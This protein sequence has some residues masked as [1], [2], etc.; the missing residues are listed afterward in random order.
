MQK[1]TIDTVELLKHIGET[2]GFEELE[3]N[4][5]VEDF[6]EVVCGFKKSE[7]IFDRCNFI[8]ENETK[9]IGRGLQNSIVFKNCNF[10][11]KV[12]WRH[13]TVSGL[14]HGKGIFTFENCIFR[15]CIEFSEITLGVNLSIDPPISFIE[16]DLMQVTVEESK[17]HDRNFYLNFSKC[18][19]QSIVISNIDKLL[20]SLEF[21]EIENLEI[22]DIGEKVEIFSDE[23]TTI[24]ETTIKWI[25]ELVICE[26]LD[27]Q[28]LSILACQEVKGYFSINNECTLSDSTFKTE[29]IS[30]SN[31][32]EEAL[33]YVDDC[34]F[35][36]TV[37]L[38]ERNY[39]FIA[40]HG[41][42]F[43]KNLSIADAS[44][45][46]LDFRGCK[47]E[48][49]VEI[50]GLKNVKLAD[51]SRSTINGLFLFSRWGDERL[52]FEK[53]VNINFSHIYLAPSGYLI[54]RDIN[55]RGKKNGNFKFNSANIL[56]TVVFTDV[57]VNSLDLEYSS[58]VGNFN[59]E[60][61]EID[62]YA[63]SQTLVKLKNEA[64]KKN[65]TIK[66]LEYKG[67][68][69]K[70]YRR[71][72]KEKGTFKN[73]KERFLITLNTCS[74]NNGQSW[75]RGL[76]FTL[77][78]AVFFC[79]LLNCGVESSD[80]LYFYYGWDGW[81]SYKIILER[82]LAVINIFDFDNKSETLNLTLFGNYLFFISKIF[83]GYGIYQTIAAFRKHGK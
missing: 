11:S 35:N 1:M 43:N 50:R 58:I 30:W 28:K 63:N 17:G 40:V 14:I 81:D 48:D 47:F 45:D 22:S 76:L 55:E 59:V 69:M 24:G 72:L 7:I 73:L 75:T 21:S 37:S 18:K 27:S 49:T 13:I 5:S 8:F 79:L 54:I 38:G 2:K 71:E 44:I 15:D 4:L 52:C 77:S 25:K 70:K 82:F 64:I 34:T 36:E 46:N 68:E 57:Y 10:N 32:E 20:L 9:K 80:K 6:F 26:Y 51:F 16:C 19:S 53:E 67:E 33:I 74:N 56:G 62:N 31:T 23:A 60:K 61:V 78:W 29:I 12:I 41:S 42:T 65:D 3:I 83:V 39:I 66:A